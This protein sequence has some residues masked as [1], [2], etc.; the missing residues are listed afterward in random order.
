MLKNSDGW[1][2]EY[3]YIDKVDTFENYY[4]LSKRDGWTLGISKE[5]CGDLV[6]LPGDSLTCYTQGFNNVVGL[7]IAGKVVR[8]KTPKEVAWER[9]IW[10]AE[11]NQ[12]KITAFLENYDVWQTQVD[13]LHPTLKARIRR[14]EKEKEP[15]HFWVEDG[16]YE[17]SALSGANAILN[18]AE[19]YHP[20]DNDRQIKFV[21]DWWD[22]NSDKHNYNYELQAA[23]IPEFGDGHSGNTAGAAKSFALGILTGSYT[24]ENYE[25][26]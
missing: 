15:Y 24:E 25:D 20:G 13:A 3:T 19:F 10:L 8:Y 21:G 14:F 5:E 9:M 17:L 2:V 22:I 11:Y 7:T 12:S 26:S 6:P 4:S 23:L 18:A 16:G 1:D